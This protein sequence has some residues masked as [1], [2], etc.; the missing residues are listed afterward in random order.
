MFALNV[1]PHIGL[2]AVG[3]VRAECTHVLASGRVLVS[4]LK[5]VGW[6]QT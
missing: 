5:Q 3:E 6:L 1:V 4:V 2:R